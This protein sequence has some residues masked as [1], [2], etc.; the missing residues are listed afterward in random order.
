MDERQLIKKIKTLKQIKPNKDWV[1]FTKRE[2]FGEKGEIKESPNLRTTLGW[3]FTPVQ[4]P[5]LVVRTLI[6]GVLILAGVFVYLY[7]GALTSQIVQLP[8]IAEKRAEVEAMKTS[9]AEIQVSL[10]E[11]KSSLNNLKN[12]RNLSQALSVTEV[13]RATANRG[14]ET[15]KQIKAGSPPKKVLATLTEVE[16]TLKE[17]KES[18]YHIQKEMIEN[19]LADLKKRDLTEEDQERL[20]K[21]QEYY[22]EGRYTEAMILIQRIGNNN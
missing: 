13:I 9:L 20:G 11:I 15:V 7:L 22:N 21:A 12:T 1:S 2:I 3:L 19:L 18:S 4:R 8:F 16:N 14:E 5:A 6:A 17:L 10:V